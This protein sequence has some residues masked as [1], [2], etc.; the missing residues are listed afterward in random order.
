LAFF[1]VLNLLG[2]AM[3]VVSVLVTIA[4]VVLQAHRHAAPT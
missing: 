3:V 4:L 1:R 2:I